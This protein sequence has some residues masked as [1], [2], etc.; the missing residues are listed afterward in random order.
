MTVILK[1]DGFNE[2]EKYLAGLCSKTFLSLWSYPNVYTDEGKKSDNGDGKELCDLLVVFDHHVIIF[3]DKDI[4]FKDTGNIEIEWGRWV[5]RAVLKSASQLYGAE[6]WI[7]ERSNR[8]YLDPKC[9]KKFPLNFPA[10]NDIKIHRIAVAKNATKRFSS[11]VKGSGSLIIN[12]LI[13]GSDHLK[14][15][16]MI[17]IPIPGKPYIHVFDDVALDVVLHELDTISDF[18]DYLEKKEEFINSEK[19]ISAAGEEDLLAFYLMNAEKKRPPGF[20]IETDHKAVILEGQYESLKRL[21]QYHRGKEYDKISYFWDGFIEHFAGHALGGTLLY[22]NKRPLSDATLGLQVM[23]SERRIARRVLSNSILEKIESTPPNK[24]SVRILVSPTNPNHGYIWLILPIPPQAQSYEEYRHYRKEL[25]YV[26]CTSA[27]LLYP[28]FNIIV[29]IATE[30]RDGGGGE[31]MIY[32][33][34]TTWEATD[35]EQAE[36]DRKDF[37]VLLPENIKQFSGIE[38]QYPIIDSKKLDSKNK[39][40]TAIKAKKTKK[41]QKKSRKLNRNRKCSNLIMI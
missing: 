2:S 19:L 39:S 16:F 4:G 24:N 11:I 41:A 17:G 5:K 20:Y 21:P 26:Y 25:L 10:P 37:G 31:D 22:E 3:S 9:Q 30:P 33:D 7:L 36:V 23:A 18:V 35:F 32:L 13:T 38:Y 34:T 40:R 27:K 6:N 29:G 15:P 1:Q 8:I 14:N 28:N 12:P